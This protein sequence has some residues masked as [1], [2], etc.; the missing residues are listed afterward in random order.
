MTE[1]ASIRRW[2]TIVVS[3][4]VLLFLLWAALGTTTGLV[5]ARRGQFIDIPGWHSP[6]VGAARAQALVLDQVERPTPDQGAIAKARLLAE[7][8]LRRDPI[9]TDATRTLG[10][11]ASLDQRQDQARRWMAFTQ[12]QSRREVPT[13]LW[14]IEDAVSRGDVA[15][16]LKHYNYALTTSR[17]TETLLFPILIASA[18]DAQMGAALSDIVSKRPIWWARFVDR[19]ISTGTTPA[20]IE[21]IVAAPRL[22]LR[23]EPEQQLA[24]RAVQRLLQL[25]SV[26]RA[27]ALYRHL[28]GSIGAQLLRNGN[29]ALGNPLPPF[30]WSLSDKPDLYASIGSVPDPRYAQGLTIAAANGGGG[31]AA[32]QLLHLSPGKYRL[33]IVAGGGAESAEASPNAQLSCYA[34][35]SS[36]I[37]TIPL[38]AVGGQ[39]GRVLS[40]DITVPVPACQFQQLEVV[41]PSIID[42]GTVETW[43][44]AVTLQPR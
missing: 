37:A 42:G 26:D 4:I 9:N 15:D 10:L 23:R 16:A 25:G 28:R 35:G 3:T 19:A 18:N 6:S 7:A 44:S 8:A 20:A 36:P 11:V 29:F 17:P 34:T 38:R 31:V 24:A 14:M 12:F 21:A 22:D 30:D 13:Q 41:V 40:A 27:Y 33:A 43:I 1:P 5:L 32:H 39:Q 2:S